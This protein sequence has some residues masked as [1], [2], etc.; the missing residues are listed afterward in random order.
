VQGGTFLERKN[1][2]KYALP[3]KL[4]QYLQTPRATVRK[5]VYKLRLSPA[6]VEMLR[7]AKNKLF[8]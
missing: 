5:A 8:K 3:V 4:F 2:A 6:H 7:I 1:A